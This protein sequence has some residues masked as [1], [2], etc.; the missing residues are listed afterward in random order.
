MARFLGRGVSTVLDKTPSSSGLQAGLRPFETIASGILR[1]TG[2]ER[3]AR[4]WLHSAN[5]ALQTH[6]PIE[7]IR[8]GRV[9]ELGSFVQD[10]LEGRP[11]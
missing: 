9:A 2:S 10:L 8:R 3:R 11:A 7:L 1:L 5:P 6:A 4:M